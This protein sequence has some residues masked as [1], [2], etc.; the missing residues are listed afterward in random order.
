MTP[1]NAFRITVLPGDGIG[2]EVT[3]PCLEVMAAAEKKIGGFSLSTDSYPAG[4][5]HFRDEGVSLPKPTLDACSKADASAP[6]SARRWIRAAC[7]MVLKAARS[8]TRR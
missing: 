1:S 4:A 6:V 8:L 5:G 3:D 7:L 2:P